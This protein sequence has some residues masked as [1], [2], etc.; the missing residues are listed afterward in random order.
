MR[1]AEVMSSIIMRAVVM[2]TL[3]TGEGCRKK[4]TL[5]S[6]TYSSPLVAVKTAQDPCDRR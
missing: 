4:T 1:M 5:F 6:V 2:I 3:K